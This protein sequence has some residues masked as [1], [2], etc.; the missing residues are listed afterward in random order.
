MRKLT[1]PLAG[2]IILACFI[3]LT[4][5]IRAQE[6]PK[7]D[8]VPVTTLITVLGPKFSAP[9]ALGRA[10]AIV[11]TGDHR[12]DITGWVPAQGTKATLQ[13]AILI[14]DGATDFGVHLD[15]VRHFIQSQPKSTNVG[16]FY[17]SMGTTQ[18]I[19]PFSADHDAVAQ[20]VRI[21]F[22]HG[23]SSTSIY[24]SL[25]DVLRK[26]QHF[27][28]RREILL[29]GDGHDRLRGDLPESPD[30]DR[31]MDTAVK[32]NVVVHTLYVHVGRLNSESFDLTLA[33]GNLAHLAAETGGQSFFQ[34]L[35]TPVS[36]TPFL[37][38]LDMALHNQYFLTFTTARSNKPKGE[39]RGFK[40][41]TEQRNAQ[42]TAPDRVFVPGAGK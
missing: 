2:L 42:I 41:T 9:P 27:P 25:I 33:Q 34:G 4:A 21:T 31:A 10:D 17:A 28:G 3:L 16:V 22:G 32:L 11:R 13:L 30:L 20:K 1:R 36:F 23:S 8:K 35:N 6:P 24:L 37:D 26:L 40:V 29:I 14:D 38:Q 19:A 18:P 12:E 5:S 7:S 39:F 15:E